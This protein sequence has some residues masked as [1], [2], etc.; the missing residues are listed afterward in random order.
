MPCLI[1]IPPPPECII[2][3]VI[4][5]QVKPELFQ[6]I[7]HYFTWMHHIYS[8]ND[9]TWAIFYKGG[10]KRAALLSQRIYEHPFQQ[11]MKENPEIVI[12]IQLQWVQR[13]RYRSGEYLDIS[14]A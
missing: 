4:K 6:V 10:T 11:Y 13:R 1:E 12:Y 5:K 3:I 7:L 9:W 14:G 2:L 8:V